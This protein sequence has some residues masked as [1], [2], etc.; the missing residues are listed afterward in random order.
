M[1]SLKNLVQHLKSGGMAV[2]K[3][4]TIYGIVADAKNRQAVEDVYNI[5]HR[6]S[7]KPCIILISDFSQAFGGDAEKLFNLATDFDT[8]TSVIVENS[9]APDYLKRGGSSLAYRRVYNS[10]IRKVV[11][12]L[13][14]VVA[15][16]ANIQG[17]L[18]AKNIAEAI[19]FFGDK[20]Y[21]FDEGEV[22]SSVKPSRIIKV[23]EN[24]IEIIRD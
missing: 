2:V 1:N 5:R 13:G 21:Y 23:T 16:S 17:F 7:E 20:V 3:T 19:N 22:L 8:P 12:E 4:D 6:K 14:A 9:D 11:D 15:P 18:P 10:T 24:K